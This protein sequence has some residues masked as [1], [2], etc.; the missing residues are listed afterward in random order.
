MRR[1]TAI[2]SGRIQAVGY[3]NIVD[4]VAYTH[5]ITG[6]VKNLKDRTVEVVAEGH[7]SSLKAFFDDIRIDESPIHV[8]TISITWDDPTNEYTYFD[9]IRGDPSEEI[10]ER[11]DVANILL[12]NMNKKQDIMILKQDIMIDKQDQMLDKQDQML[13]KQDQMLDKQD[14]MLDKQDQMLDVGRET[15]DE[16]TGLRKDTG[17][18]LDD[19]FKEIK[20]ELHSIKDAL[21]RAGIKV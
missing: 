20:K 13:D 4:T 18:F 6:Y 14:Q 19:E 11:M 17:K 1:A 16:I 10:G 2:V 5:K 8:D 15:K 7:E 21:S 3:R 9:I 12:M